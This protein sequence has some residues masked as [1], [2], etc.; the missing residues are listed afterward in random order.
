MV[1]LE[2]L[3]E[4]TAEDEQ[5]RENERLKKLRENRLFQ[6][7]CKYGSPLAEQI[8]EVEKETGKRIDE[9]V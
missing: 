2:D 8:F 1:E 4:L 3:E 6:L 5:R 9:N 7:K